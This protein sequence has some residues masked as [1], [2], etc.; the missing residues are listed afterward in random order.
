MILKWLFARLL[1]VSLDYDFIRKDEKMMAK[2]W[3]NRLLVGS[4]T[5][6]SVPL[7]YADAVRGYGIEYVKQGKMSVEEYEMIFKEDYP[8]E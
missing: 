3:F 2:I 4:A 8:A 1:I 6:D 7:K 5:W